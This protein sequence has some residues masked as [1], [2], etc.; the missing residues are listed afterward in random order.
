MLE[1]VKEGKVTDEVIYLSAMEQAKYRAAQANAARE[2][3]DILLFEDDD[4]TF[5]DFGG[6]R[7][8]PLPPKPPMPHAAAVCRYAQTSNFEHAVLHHRKMA[9]N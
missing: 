7:Q 1:G 3:R 6:G 4:E 2:A 5:S 9:A 8:A